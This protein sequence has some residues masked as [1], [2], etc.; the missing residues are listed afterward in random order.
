MAATVS[1][2]TV[3]GPY[4]YSEMNTMSGALVSMRSLSGANIKVIQ[5]PKQFWVMVIEET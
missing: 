5:S 4:L 1:K 3:N 2:A